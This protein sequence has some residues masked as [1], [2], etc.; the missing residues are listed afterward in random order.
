MRLSQKPQNSKIS[1][2]NI[3]DYG[4]CVYALQNI[5]NTGAELILC[6]YKANYASPLPSPPFH[7]E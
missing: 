1:K 5:L 7:S 2:K 3:I 6:E 4:T